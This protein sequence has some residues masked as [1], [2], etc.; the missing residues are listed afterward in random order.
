M[1]GMTASLSAMATPAP[2][3]LV[4][5]AYEIDLRPQF[6]RFAT[7]ALRLGAVTPGHL[8][9][10]VATGPGTLAFLAA[11]LG[12][13]VRAID[14]AEEMVALVRAR[15]A[16]EGVSVDVSVG[17]GMT[18]PWAD[19]S[20]DAAFSM[21]GLMFFPDRARGFGEL[22]RVLRTG[23]R[24]IVSSWTPLDGIPFYKELFATLQAE[25]PHLPLGG[26]R[27]ALSSPDEMQGEM[28]SAG[29]REVVVHRVV[30]AEPPATVDD[31]WER[32]GRSMAPLVLLRKNLGEEA[33]T[34]L[35][36]A[37][38]ERLVACFG[39]KLGPVT[40]VANVG[41]GVR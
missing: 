21:F 41:V 23:G 14:F 9:A 28:A 6:E 38:R 37:V 17:D 36:L 7:D 33:W 4:A 5:S 20:F 12:A 34:R 3:N 10:D 39:V 19:A 31:A 2:W 8:V 35:G 18:L 22:R 27:L 40:L 16:R 11:K 13:T 30:H 1:R 26:S 25:L 29:F 24:A 15:I 32:V